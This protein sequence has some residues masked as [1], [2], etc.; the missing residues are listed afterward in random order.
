M[1]TSVIHYSRLVLVSVAVVLSQNQQ[2]ASP[3]KQEEEDVNTIP[4]KQNKKN[5]V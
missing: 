4:G 5:S 2:K 1:R 3:A